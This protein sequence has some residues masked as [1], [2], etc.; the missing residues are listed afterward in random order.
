[1]KRSEAKARIESLR[2][3]I[4]K[5]DHRYYVLADPLISD[6]AYDRLMR[7]LASL[8]SAFP[9]LITPDSPTQR[10]GGEVS[11]GFPA[12]VHS[13]PMLSILNAYEESEVLEFD[14]RVRKL[15]GASGVS[16][17]IEPKIDG[18][19]ISLVYERGG[20]VRGA[21]RGDGE[22]GDDITANLRTVRQ[23]PMRLVGE[24]RVPRRLEVRGEVYMP[25]EAFER[26]NREQLDR[27]GK[28]FANP[29]NATAGS[30]K[31][32]DP[33]IVASRPLRVFVHSVVGG[34]ALGVRTHAEAL[35]RVREMGLRTVEHLK[36]VDGIRGALEWCW[37]WE[38]RRHSLAYQV[39]GMVIK[40]NDLGAQET[41]GHTSKNPRWELALKFPAL[42]ATT[43]VKEIVA[44]VGRTGVVTP[45]AVL[46]PV[47]LAGSNIS[48][49]TLH[50]EDEIRRKDI[51]V[52]DTVVIQKG[53][54]V[55]PKVVKVILDDR[56]G[57]ERAYRMP[58]RC[59]SCGEPLQRF[60]EE[61]AVRC[62]NIRCPV[63]VQRRIQH[64]ASRNGMDIEGLGGV[65]V[66]NLVV[67]GLVS[68]V[69]DLYG[70]DRAVVAGLE[71]MG[72]KSAENLM[73]ALEKSK[74][75]G[76]DRLIFGLGI[77]N[78]GARAARILAEH[79]GSID[80]LSEAGE[81]ELAELGEIGPTIAAS[82]RDFF[83][84]PSAR[85]VLEKLEKAGV[86]ME[87][88]PGRVGG[89]LEGLR[90]VV[91]GTIAALSRGEV[92]SLVRSHGGEVSS[93]VS[94]KT[95]YV[96]AGEK[97]G[98]K[99]A[100]ARALGVPVIDIDALERMIRSRG[101]GEGG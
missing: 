93:S 55:I 28:L 85:V 92:E 46:E 61:V 68:D 44:Q 57:K 45:V 67:G 11:E 15:L 36:V 9:D 38:A 82:V 87:R 14:E 29:R 8:E 47:P 33:R 101:A 94:G 42:E 65:L 83:S 1:M 3:E 32:L 13:T 43:K 48:R 10:V 2:R 23:I 73:R 24:G 78:V 75:Q 77:R 50:N 96:I 88:R 35:E 52:G 66:E 17:A 63:Q 81:E 95:N 49:A 100:K 20:F 51:R 40:V 21:T 53:G 90:F 31:L 56:T 54:D 79:Y 99:L 89:P 26:L 91:T 84:R 62:T 72:E 59:P 41:L 37:A 18:V 76:L 71:R 97:P 7:E 74:T 34:E 69:G 5:H 6:E 80:R 39:D 30:L 58:D 4:R 19:A 98:L 60:P 25:T 86:Q 16:Y 64:Y 12:V 22:R 70:L 27:G